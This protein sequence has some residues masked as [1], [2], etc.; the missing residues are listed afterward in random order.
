[1]MDKGLVTMKNFAQ[2]KNK[3]GY[4]DL[5]WDFRTKGI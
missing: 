2:S 5:S 1:M 4:V 3:F